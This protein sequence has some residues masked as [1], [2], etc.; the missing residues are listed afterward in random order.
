MFKTV[1]SFGIF[2]AFLT[3]AQAISDEQQA[4]IQAKFVEFGSEC[5]K[6]HPVSFEDLTSLRQKVFPESGNAGCFTACIFNK[7][8]LFDD[9]GTLSHTTALE[10]AKKVF[11][12]KEELKSIEEFLTACAKVNEEAVSDG[13]KGCERAKLAYKCYVDNYEKFNFDLNF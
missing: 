12:D 8:G 6:N 4:Q 2:A 5:I 10:S 9:K 3:Y 7:I 11:E 13:E 1:I